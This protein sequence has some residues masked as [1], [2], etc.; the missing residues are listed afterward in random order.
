MITCRDARNLFDRYLDDEL[1]PSLQTELNAHRL[2]CTSCQNELAMAE[3]FGD[4]VGLDH[5]EPVLSGS[6]TDRVLLA[7]RAQARPPR[8]NWSRVALLIGSPMAAAAS[9]VLA[10]AVISP[11]ET[12]VILGQQVTNDALV[13]PVTVDAPVVTKVA[14]APAPAAG[15]IE[16][17][18]APLVEQSRNTLEGTRRSA[19]G[20]AYLLHLGL[21]D[22]NE[23]LVAH[24][25]SAQQGARTSGEFSSDHGFNEF[26]LPNAG[27]TTPDWRNQGSSSTSEV[28]RPLQPL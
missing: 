3:A 4:V 20:L 11:P 25:E 26:D 10:F 27:P 24:W 5:T 13:A 22:T 9:I 16:G 14:E 18:L 12:T 23:M 17:L 28:A 19:Q 1:P 21:S 8:R 7:R 15:F 6:F 2:N